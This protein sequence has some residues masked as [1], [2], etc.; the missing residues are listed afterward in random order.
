[1]AASRQIEAAR[2]PGRAAAHNRVDAADFADRPAPALTVFA[3]L[4]QVG[5]IDG[6]TEQPALPQM[7]EPSGGSPGGGCGD[8]PRPAAGG[9]DM[10]RV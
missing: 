7:L 5:F 3:L 10:P 9:Q 1:M 6:A 2:L 4:M 8:P